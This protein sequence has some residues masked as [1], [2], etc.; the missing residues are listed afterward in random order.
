MLAGRYEQ[1]EAVL[2][3]AGYR[4]EEISNWA[5]PGHEC[6]HNLLYWQQGDY[7]GIGSAAH[8]HRAGVRWWNVRTPERYTAAWRPGGRP[9]RGARC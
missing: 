5:L 4:W 9:R 6:R 1:A 2:G 8:S 3:A 7:L